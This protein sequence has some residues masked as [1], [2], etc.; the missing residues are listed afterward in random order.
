[1]KLANIPQDIRFFNLYFVDETKN[2]GTNKAF[3]KF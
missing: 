1:M 3:E 2:P